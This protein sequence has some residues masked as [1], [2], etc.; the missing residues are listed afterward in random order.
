[1]RSIPLCLTLGL[2]CAAALSPTSALAAAGKVTYLDG[3]AN[4]I[5]SGGT[6]AALSMDQDVERGDTIATGAGAKLE[7]TLGDGSVVRMTE[8]SR[9]VLDRVEA[10]DVG[11]KVRLS[12]SLGAVWAKVSKRSEGEPG[13]EVQTQRVVAGVRGTQFFV[14]TADDH[15]VVVLEGQVNVSDPKGGLLGDKAV[16]EVTAMKAIAVKEGGKTE[17]VIGIEGRHD[18]ATLIDWVRKFDFEK[19][20]GP[21]RATWME[22]RTDRREDHRADRR[23]QRIYGH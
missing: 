23:E 13:F 1:M 17:G 11:W 22:R 7:I 6:E 18:F 10:V 9:L 14:D 8:N 21:K 3:S 12:L 2:S 15:A 19:S 16:H 20:H 5:P 4:R